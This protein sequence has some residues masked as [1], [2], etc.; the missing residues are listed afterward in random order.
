M[1]Y[2]TENVHGG[3]IY[4]GDIRLDFSSNTNPFGTPPGVIEAIS[5]AL[6]S[7]HCYP[8]PY[9]RDLLQAISRY[10]NIN[11]DYILCGNGAAELIYSY[12]E[13]AKPRSAVEL[14]PTF[15]EYSLGLERVNCDIIRY[16]LNRE[17]DFELQ[18]E[19]L[20]FLR[21]TVPDAVFICNPNNPTG[22]TI[23]P[24]L[25]QEILTVTRENG[26]RLFVD[27]CFL[28]LSD[29]GVSLKNSLVDNPQLF[30]LKAFTKNYGMAG[31]RLG[32]CITADSDLLLKMSET[33]QPWNVSGLAQ[34]AGVA[35]LNEK[36]FLL[37]AG[38]LISQER[39]WLK[40]QLEQMGYYVCPSNAN[41]LLFNAPSDLQV[42]LREQ[43]ILVRSCANY[44]GL[45]ACWFRIAVKL[46]H[47]NEELINTMKLLY[48]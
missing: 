3:D 1:L 24:K 25:L 8:D 46:H 33:V 17:N 43:G 11:Q 38:E 6:S 23:C 19:F 9:C 22:K 39:A 45:D 27:E 34:A 48:I 4:A 13:A 37:D 15:A 35:A 14:A 16:S 42:R 7:V 47:Q 40:L 2:K 28:D 32:Y 36:K 29:N 10:E 18:R 5:A 21:G 31:V 41:Y 12:C 26:I 44:H 30:I 20:D